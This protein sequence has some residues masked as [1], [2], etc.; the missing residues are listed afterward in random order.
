MIPKSLTKYNALWQTEENLLIVRLLL[1]PV[2]KLRVKNA[3]IF[4][5]DL[6]PDLK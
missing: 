1:P 6:L 3:P 5:A 2:V 4:Q